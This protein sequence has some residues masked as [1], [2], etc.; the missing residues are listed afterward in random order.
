MGTRAEM[1]KE[2]FASSQCIRRYRCQWHP[3]LNSA[4]G[5]GMTVV[6]APVVAG[7]TK[8]GALPIATDVLR[9]MFGTL[10]VDALGGKDAPRQLARLIKQIGHRDPNRYVII[11][12]V[13]RSIQVM[14]L[15][16][17]PVATPVQPQVSKVRPTRKPQWSLYDGLSMRKLW[18]PWEEVN[19]RS[20]PIQFGHREGNAAGFLVTTR[21]RAIVGGEY[22]YT[23][24]QTS[25][26]FANDD[27]MDR[28]EH[29]Y[30]P[31]PEERSPVRLADGT[32]APIDMPTLMVYQVQPHAN[33]RY[34]LMRLGINFFPSGNRLLGLS[35][36]IGDFEQYLD[37][38][39]PT[40][41]IALR[42]AL[43]H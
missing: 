10:T 43:T 33:G 12:P 42:Q 29:G 17:G 1:F 24:E 25:F 13:L 19:Q 15:N 8:Y 16:K 36:K 2:L 4:V 38:Y 5:G 37:F 14:R 39:D 6:H 23:S 21:D 18:V 41:E 11:M 35:T 27:D 34:G 30:C 26:V 28:V 9:R 3:M 31:H 20:S 32:L 40:W 22:R 7:P